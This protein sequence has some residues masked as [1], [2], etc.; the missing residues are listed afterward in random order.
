MARKIS[1]DLI[2]AD[3]NRHNSQ[4]ARQQANDVSSTGEAWKCALAVYDQTTRVVAVD[5]AG[6]IVVP[7][8]HEGA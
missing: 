6:L 1:T 3:A 5:A 2:V 4:W 8:L 7:A